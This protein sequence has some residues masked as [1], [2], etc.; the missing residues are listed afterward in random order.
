LYGKHVWAA[1]CNAHTTL[2]AQEWERETY[3]MLGSGF[4]GLIYYQ[5]RADYDNGKGPEIGAFGIL[6]NNR[7]KT[8]KFPVIEPMNRLVEKLSPVLAPAERMHGPVA[9]L[10]SRHVNAW[11]DGRENGQQGE[12][13]KQVDDLTPGDC[14]TA[15]D[16]A[17]I[18]TEG[19]Y[20]EWRKLG[21][22][23]VIL[24]AEDLKENKLGVRVLIVPSAL[25]LSQTEKEQIRA[26]AEAGGLVYVY[27]ARGR[28]SGYALLP[29]CHARLTARPFRKT[30]VGHRY[31]ADE[32][33]YMAQLDTPFAVRCGIGTLSLNMMKGEEGY[34]ET[35]INIDS[36]EREIADGVISLDKE[37]FADVRSA[38]FHTPE[39]EMQLQLT[40]NEGRLEIALPP[41]ATGCFVVL[42]R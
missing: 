2:T 5:W 39:R 29:G 19:I 31:T 3:A 9:I 15:F 20:R 37:I 16:R 34:V 21:Q 28:D 24:R 41:V 38:C 11:F 35:L 23:P 42:G 13:W 32:I 36:F 27:H 33:V 7:E 12:F 30:P 10:F 4:K 22:Q 25:C 1:E 18:L 17:T 8:E 6:H 14:Q 26:F 40:E